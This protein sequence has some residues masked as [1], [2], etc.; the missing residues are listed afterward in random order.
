MKVA[1]IGGG[2]TGLAAAKRLL[3]AGHHVDIYEKEAK[4]GGVAASINYEDT[5]L[6]IFYHHIFTS[7]HEI[8]ALIEELGLKNQLKWLESKMGFYIDGKIYEFGTPISL[9]KFKPLAFMDKIRFG[10]SVLRLQMIQD[11]RPLERI[12]AKE[13]LVKHAGEKAYKICWEPLLT[14]KFGEKHDQISMAWFWGKIKL[15]G[16]TR[17]DAKTKEMLGYVMGSFEEVGTKLIEYVQGLGAQIKYNSFVKN[18]EFIDD[19]VVVRVDQEEVQYDKVLLTVPLPV[20]G[21]LVQGLSRHDLQTIDQIEYT[22][23][24]CS[25]LKLNQS[26]SDIYWLNI[27][28]MDIPFGGLIEHTNMVQ[29]ARYNGKHI[30]YISNYMFE[31]DPLYQAQ[32]DQIKAEYIYHLQKINPSFHEGWIEDFQIF[33]AKYAQPMIKCNYSSLKPEF[34]TSIPH[35]YIANMTHIYP[36]DRGMNYAIRTGYE[37]VDVMLHDSR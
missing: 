10:I 27:G 5:K 6:E 9:L 23:V 32:D 26:Y 14:S 29:D 30:L 37:V 7:D 16:S 34:Q 1:I 22:S 3:E 36:E 4:L 24:I 25:V 20:V 8:I 21:H 33:K 11:W 19:H 15:R 31:T 13:W 17:S 28:D 35:V 12:T 18:V 2:F